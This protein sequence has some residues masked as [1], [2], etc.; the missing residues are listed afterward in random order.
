[1]AGTKPHQDLAAFW[2]PFTDNRGFKAHPPDSV[3]PSG[4]RGIGAPSG[5]PRQ[6]LIMITH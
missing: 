2:M 5:A 1:M 4:I 6:K 3:L